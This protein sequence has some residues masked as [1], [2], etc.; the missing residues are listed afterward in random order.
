MAEAGLDPQTQL[1]D[2]RHA[3]ATMLLEQGVHPAVAS[4]VLGHSSVAFTIDTYQH[5][6]DL[7]TDQAAS[8]LANASQPV[9]QTQNSP[10][11]TVR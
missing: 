8:S 1:H 3:V 9:F 6:V 4:P 5:V 10:T 11:Q 2:C 7:M